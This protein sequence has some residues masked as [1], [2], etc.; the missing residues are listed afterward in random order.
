MMNQPRISCSV[1]G[2]AKTLQGYLQRDADNRKEG[3]Q[4]GR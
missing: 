1:Y 2:Y 3:G 4:Y